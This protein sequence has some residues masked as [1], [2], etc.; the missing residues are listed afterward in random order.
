MRPLED[1]PNARLQFGPAVYKQACASGGIHDTKG[2]VKVV[3]L[4]F[5]GAYWDA[6]LVALPKTEQTN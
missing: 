3:P 1:R 6:A 4:E 2:F 5:L